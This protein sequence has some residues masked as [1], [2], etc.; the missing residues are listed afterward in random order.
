MTAGLLALLRPMLAP[1][2]RDRV[3]ACLLLATLVTLLL[4]LGSTPLLV[5]AAPNPPW[6]KLAHAAVFGGFGG[7]AWVAT[8]ARTVRLPFAIVAVVALADETLQY[9]APGRTADLRDIVADL[10]GA[11]VALMVLRA[12]QAT[13]AR[14]FAGRQLPGARR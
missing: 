1:A 8:G 14:R 9:Y 11:L 5:D 3:G 13:Q 6:D 10:S 4:A 2:P 12:L 7:L